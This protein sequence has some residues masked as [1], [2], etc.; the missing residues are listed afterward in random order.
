V[1]CWDVR[2]AIRISK[3]LETVKFKKSRNKEK[4]K[5]PKEIMFRYFYMKRARTQFNIGS[6][7]IYHD[8]PFANSQLIWQFLVA[9]AISTYFPLAGTLQRFEKGMSRIFIVGCT[10]ASVNPSAPP[11]ERLINS[12]CIRK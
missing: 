10:L 5:I 9:A 12:H 7:R 6:R 11:R 1:L 2:N 8:L 4:Q 3:Y